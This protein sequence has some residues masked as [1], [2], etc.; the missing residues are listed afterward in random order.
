MIE[1]ERDRAGLGQIAAAL[2]ERRA[3]FAG[4][5]IAIVGQDFDDDRDAARSIAFV[6]DLLV[7][8]ALAAQGFLD[9]ALD[10][11][12]GHIL[13]AGRDDRR[14]QPRIHRRIGCAELCRHRDFARQLA[15]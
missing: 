12:L 8:L 13:R 7:I 2:G 15:K 5:P 4:G 1:H 3:H 9:G 10:I 11:V 14:A 6:A